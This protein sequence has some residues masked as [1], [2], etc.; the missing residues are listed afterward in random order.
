SGNYGILDQIA[1]LQW[2]Q[3]N[4]K[5]FGGNPRKV[6]IFGESAGGISVHTLLASPRAAGLYH[7][8]IVES[9]A[10]FLQPTL[11]AQEPLGTALA[12]TL[13]CSDQTA[14]CLRAV[15]EDQIVAAQGTSL[16]SAGP[17]I[18]GVVIP[19]GL[20]S[21]FKNGHFNHVPVIEGSNH[22]EFRLFVALLLDLMGG[23]LTEV[24]YPNAVQT[25]LN[26]PSF[27]VPALIAQ[28]PVANYA[29][30]DLAFA[31][32]ATD[33]AFACNAHAA[34][35]SFSHYV[36]SYAYEFD[37]VNAPELFLPPV[38]FP[39][40]ASHA[41]EIQYLFDIPNLVGAP[42]L[43]AAQQELSDTMITYWTRFARTGR[44]NAAHVSAR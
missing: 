43:T 8:A 32:L 30:P 20:Q 9:G 36:R 16:N 11:A 25:I 7:R 34:V 44:P 19:E 38:S 17:V 1:A 33:A 40:G 41:S 24:A 21:A 18:D 31:T 14:A 3:R 10:V 42:P 28:Y 15:S 27:I 6:T 13:G 37:D 23:P 12:T 35:R 39:Y 22:D 26:V 29:S 5:A 2:V 4:I